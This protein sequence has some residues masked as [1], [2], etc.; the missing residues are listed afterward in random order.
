MIQST[1]QITCY[2]KLLTKHSNTI[3]KNHILLSYY[4]V[5][6][7]KFMCTRTNTR[8]KQNQIQK[9]NEPY[10]VVEP[11]LRG[12]YFQSK[13]HH[14][15]IRGSTDCG[16]RCRAS[17]AYF[18]RLLQSHRGEVRMH[19]GLP[20]S[21]PLGVVVAQQSVQKVERLIRDQ[22]LI[23][24]G[25]EATPRLARVA[26]QNTFKLGVQ[27]QVVLIQVLEQL[28]CTKNLHRKK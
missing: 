18:Q 13:L 22:V 21:Q 12:E 10:Y 20:R 7:C 27:L 17:T 9:I 16:G 11:P 14:S 26:A 15:A 5:N 19:L 1:C 8:C 25:H 28:V 6:A 4:G 23:L 3:P 2:S 24:R